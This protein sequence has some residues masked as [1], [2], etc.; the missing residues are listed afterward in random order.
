VMGVFVEK[1]IMQRKGRRYVKIFAALFLLSALFQ[2]IGSGMTYQ[3]TQGYLEEHYAD[4]GDKWVARRMMNL[5]PRWNLVTSNAKW[6]LKGYTDF[7]YMNYLDRSKANIAKYMWE[8]DP[9]VGMGI[10]LTFLL[11]IFPASG[12]LLLKVFRGHPGTDPEVGHLRK[13]K[14]P[15]R[16]R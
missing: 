9:P 13:E 3:V 16:K 4:P 11:I 5:D 12:F 2:F 15:G 8:D 1:H 14:P 7:M 6:L 10:S